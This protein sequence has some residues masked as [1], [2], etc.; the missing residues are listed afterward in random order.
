MLSAAE[1]SFHYVFDKNYDLEPLDKIEHFIK[2]N[3]H[4]PDIPNSSTIKKDGIDLVEMNMILLKKIE[5]L[6]LYAIEQNKQIEK[7]Q[8]TIELLLK[9][10]K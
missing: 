4:L 2:R 1:A 10:L 8:K 5:E 3:G 6:T 9:F 7:Q